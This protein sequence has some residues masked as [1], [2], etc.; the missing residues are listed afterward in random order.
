[1]TSP[2]PSPSPS[3]PPASG[4]RGREDRWRGGRGSDSED[5]PRSQRGGLDDG[6][7]AR[8]DRPESSSARR[9]VRSMVFREEESAALDELDDSEDPLDEEEDAPWEEPTHVTRKRARGRRAG[10]RVAARASRPERVPGTYDDFHGLCLLY[11]QPGHRAA[12][13]TTGPVCLRCGEAGHM[14]RECSLPHPAE[15]C[16]AVGRGRGAG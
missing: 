11:T 12:N 15:T 7:V 13:C 16:V 9:E 2:T 8:N 6:W 1:M 14:A 5:T 4:P 3:P 10:K